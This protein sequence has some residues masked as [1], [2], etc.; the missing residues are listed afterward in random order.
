MT[1]FRST[2]AET[3]YVSGDATLPPAR[4]EP[5]GC[6]VS[7]APPFDFSSMVSSTVQSLAL[8]RLFSHAAC[9]A[10]SSFS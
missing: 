10:G 3:V 1:V 2:L 4:I 7:V 6:R 8:F 9:F 5:S